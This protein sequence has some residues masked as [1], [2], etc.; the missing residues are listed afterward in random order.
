MLLVWLLFIWNP[1]HLWDFQ[2]SLPRHVH[3][4]LHLC[5]GILML[6][7]HPSLPEYELYYKFSFNCVI[8]LQKVPGKGH[9]VPTWPLQPQKFYTPSISHI[10]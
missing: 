5:T 2:Q 7:G 9:T 8:S 3:G 1:K 6:S 10:Y 4:A